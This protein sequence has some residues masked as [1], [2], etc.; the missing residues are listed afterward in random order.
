MDDM[1]A[2]VFTGTGN[3]IWSNAS[4]G[5]YLLTMTNTDS[6]CGTMNH[7]INVGQPMAPDA[8]VEVSPDLCNSNGNGTIT[9]GLTGMGNYT[10]TLSNSNG[11]IVLTGQGNSEII[12]VD[13]LHVGA[14]TLQIV[15]ECNTLNLG[16]D[17]TD[18]FAASSFIQ[19]SADS[20]Y[21]ESGGSVD[22]T[23]E[24]VSDN[25]T[26]FIWL[27]NGMQVGSDQVLVYS[28]NT[29]SAYTFTLIS[30]N[31]TCSTTTTAT[32]YGVITTGVNEFRQNL[33]PVTMNQNGNNIILTFHTESSSN[34]DVMIYNAMGQVI[35][36]QR[37]NSS[38][39]QVITIPMQNWSAGMY[40]VHVVSDQKRLFTAKAFKH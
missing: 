37:G 27:L 1:G 6:Q 18:P 40:T 19:S 35:Y 3:S 13:S 30:S 31:N 5:H 11:E 4:G 29:N 14:Y 25:A 36:R 28:I 20:V 15:G 17:L 10:Y 33:S 22:V 16:A 39:G 32:V 2:N 38:S 21:F 9:A 12:E 24:A 8:W 34:A 7:D 23:L 26:N